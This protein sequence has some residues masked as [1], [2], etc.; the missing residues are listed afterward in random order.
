M[1]YFTIIHALL[2]N[3]LNKLEAHD[4]ESGH[5]DLSDLLRGTVI[6]TLQQPPPPP[7]VNRCLFVCLCVVLF[8]WRQ[9]AYKPK[10]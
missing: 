8:L 5:C 2:F 10:S 3:F 6:V 4:L 9:K 7:L 1:G